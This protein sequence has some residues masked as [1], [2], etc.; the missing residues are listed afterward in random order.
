MTEV[1]EK[2]IKFAEASIRLEI[3]QGQYNVA[4]QELLKVMQNGN[5]QEAQK[6]VSE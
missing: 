2:K 3:A 1:E 4:R 5:K 6:P